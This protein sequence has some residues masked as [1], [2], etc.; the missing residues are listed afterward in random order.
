MKNPK[1]TSKQAFLELKLTW[2][3]SFE[4]QK[5]VSRTYFIYFFT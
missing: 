5:I 3:K 2:F 4:G 1:W